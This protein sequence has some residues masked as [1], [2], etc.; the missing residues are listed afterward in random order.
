MSAIRRRTLLLGATALAAAGALAACG[1]SSN[2]AVSADDMVLGQ[3]NAPLT[4]IEYASSTCPHCAHFHETV[5]ETLKTNY[6]DTG[7]VRFVYREY[8]TAPAPVAVA[9]FQVARCGGASNEQYFTRLGEI[10]RQQHAMF[11]TG[12]MEGVRAKLVEIGAAAG[13][14]QDQV[15]QCITDEAGAERIRRVVEAGDRDFQITGTPTF[16][17]NGQKVDDPAFVTPEGLTR[18]LD[19]ALAE[20][21]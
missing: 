20:H 17:I 8:P 3:A 11:A 7:K 6:I 9:A 19:A 2:G 13:L 10:Y 16:V 15:M 18:I 14:T 4:L 1:G 21:N 5:W 12:T